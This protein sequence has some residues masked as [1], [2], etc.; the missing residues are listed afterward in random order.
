MSE[1]T[2]VCVPYG[3][4]P[5]SGEILM[6]VNNLDNPKRAMKLLTSLAVE[7]DYISFARNGKTYHIFILCNEYYQV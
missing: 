7:Y 2:Q 6:A 5:H 3:I 4:D 1:T